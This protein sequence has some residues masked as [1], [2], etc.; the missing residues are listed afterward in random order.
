MIFLFISGCKKDDEPAYSLNKLSGFV[1]KGPYI[2]GSAITVT[3]LNENLNPTGKTFSSQ[4]F[5]NKGSFEVNEVSLNSMYVEIRADGFYFDEI[6]GEKSAAQLTLF[7]LADISNKN[8]INVNILTQLEK[9]RVEYLVEQGLAFRDAKV[10]A[11][12]EVLNAF[13]FEY[14]NMS[15]SELLDISQQEERNAILLAISI[16][17][18]ANRSVG[19]LTELIANIS[20]DLSEDGVLN[21]DIL[22][23]GLLN[24]ARSI[25]TL[26]VRENL[27]SRYESMG[28]EA[29]FP[30]FEKYLRHYIENENPIKISYTKK[31][32]SCNG[33][34]DGEIDI[35]MEGGTAPFAYHWSNEESS[36]DVSGLSGADYWVVITDANNYK[37]YSDII[38]INEPDSLSI[39]VIVV[40]T[41]EVGSGNG[42]IDITVSGGTS[43]YIYQWSGGETT[44]DISNLS[45]GGYTVTVEDSNGCSNSSY[46]PLLSLQF[47]TKDVTC[48]G[49]TDGEINLILEGGTSPYTF[50]WSNGEITEDISNISAGS[51]S[52]SITDA[53]NYQ[54]TTEEIFINEPDSIIILE[55]EVIDIIV[56]DQYGSIDITAAGGTP[57]YAFLWSNGDETEDISNLLSGGDYNITVSDA[58]FCN[59]S[60][61]IYLNSLFVDPRDGN[62]YKFIK[63]GDQTWMAENLAYLPSVSPESDTSGLNN[64][65]SYLVYDYYGYNVSE[66]KSTTN[67]QTYGVLYNWHAAVDGCPTGWHL[68]SL[69]EWTQL[70]DYLG[71]SGVAGG[72]LKESKFAALLGGTFGWPYNLEFTRIN[73]IGV[74]FT[75]SE[76]KDY[77]YEFPE[78][79]IY[80]N[81][82]YIMID[83][84]GSTIQQDIRLKGH[85]YSVRC[86][87][88]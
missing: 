44:E 29:T 62:N 45:L 70:I 16:I 74:W 24:Q 19:D 66:A 88:D 12:S 53:F 33:M 73:E 32:V 2:N 57:P 17:L 79:K 4:I 11:Q 76:F 35:T 43:P 22:K 49:Y 15:S 47:E 41:P 81:A 1:Q 71:G 14:E 18:Q 5:D 38:A 28:G 63:I 6:K 36:E 23:S 30:D 69:A 34:D 3:E 8:T 42:A 77:F 64:Q 37:F 25:D 20:N 9:R 72:K 52:V 55:K 78:Y 85:G 65:S 27:E 75:S 13:G 7:G 40:N 56:D 82:Y 83:G 59:A 46:I 51:Y 50:E 21:S 58:N 87:K 10:Q 48:N 39:E 84:G 67:Y 61:S 60:L 26:S 68:P 54:F 80:P 31:D 86:I